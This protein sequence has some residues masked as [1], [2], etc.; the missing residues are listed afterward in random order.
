MN[1]IKKAFGA[2]LLATLIQ[3][4]EVGLVPIVEQEHTRTLVRDAFVDI[5]A[6][7][8]VKNMDISEIKSLS[9]TSP[10]SHGTA[11]YNPDNYTIRYQA[12][13]SY[14]GK[15][16]ISFTVTTKENLSADG[17]IGIT[18][19]VPSSELDASSENVYKPTMAVSQLG[20]LADAT[21]KIYELN[22][23]AVWGDGSEVLK[24]TEV[25]SPEAPSL[26]DIGVFDAH[27]AHLDSSKYYVYESIKGMDWDRDD[28]G[29]KDASATPNL[30][31]FHLIIKGNW[32]SQG[33]DVKLFITPS[34][35]LQIRKMLGKPITEDN[36]HETAAEVGAKD[37][38][39]D[40]EIDGKD[41]SLQD[42]VANKANEYGDASVDGEAMEALIDEI[43][44][45]D[46][47]T[48]E[49]GITDSNEAKLG[50]NTTKKDTD[51]DGI[52][53]GDEL[54]ID[55]DGDGKFN[56]NDNDDDGDT[57]LTKDELSEGDTDGDGKE[58]YLDNDDD[59]DG[60]LTGS[61]G[62]PVGLDRDHDGLPD[63]LE[64]LSLENKFQLIS[65]DF[66]FTDPANGVHDIWVAPRFGLGR[67]IYGMIKIPD[68]TEPEDAVEFNSKEYKVVK[69]GDEAVT[70]AIV[71]ENGDNNPADLVQ[72]GVASSVAKKGDTVFVTSYR[73]IHAYDVADPLAISFVGETNV[74]NDLRELIAKEKAD[75]IYNTT[76]Y[77]LGAFGA[78]FRVFHV[79]YDEVMDKLFV[80]TSRGVLQYTTDLALEK[81]FGQR[82]PF[83]SSA[84]AYKDKTSLNPNALYGLNRNGWLVKLNMR[85][86]EERWR[87]KNI[88][89]LPHYRFGGWGFDVEI[90]AN[91]ENAIIANYRYLTKIDLTIPATSSKMRENPRQYK[92]SVSEIDGCNRIVGVT[93]D[94]EDPDGSVY[95]S[96]GNGAI[97]HTAIPAEPVNEAG[98]HINR[99]RAM[100]LIVNDDQTKAYVVTGR[101]GSY[102]SRLRGY[103]IDIDGEFYM[104]GGY[105]EL[106]PGAFVAD[107]WFKD[108]NKNYQSRR[109]DLISNQ[110]EPPSRERLIRPGSIVFDPANQAIAYATSYRNIYEINLETGV[111]VKI[112][113]DG[114]EDRAI[115]D[116]VTGL[117]RGPLNKNT[118]KMAIASQATD[119]GNLIFGR[120][121]YSLGT[122]IAKGAPIYSTKVQDW[123]AE[124]GNRYIYH[125]LVRRNTY[126]WGMDWFDDNVF[127]ALG[128]KGV[129]KAVNADVTQDDHALVDAKTP[130]EM[131]SRGRF[132]SDIQIDPDDAP[133]TLTSNGFVESGLFLITKSRRIEQCSGSQGM[134]IVPAAGDGLAKTH[135][136]CGNKIVTVDHA[137]RDG[138]EIFPNLWY[139]A[140]YTYAKE[141]LLDYIDQPYR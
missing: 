29:V 137:I 112:A 54:Q 79:E 10:T 138:R 32:C 127:I 16:T 49:D 104:D 1:R 31:T 44:N 77:R 128:Y 136:A 109:G 55:T 30:G 93:I 46:A 27:C 89:T 123:E 18:V 37:Q 70:H 21:V 130:R 17:I 98:Q 11:Y 102:R 26:A 124:L 38:N 80:S 139:P 13:K 56:C 53:D 12:D 23:G 85:R 69:D 19:A 125:T 135:V 50:C 134:Y 105:D 84:R 81:I 65:R 3:A 68:S 36:L 83:I 64:I 101:E 110:P 33:Q 35:E 42:P 132:I 114:D 40:G 141:L 28:D 119:G 72:G 96:C 34:S 86:D 122:S 113:E 129:A 48:D 100:D 25:T 133:K 15:D 140:G 108:K 5:N 20:R 4:G 24:W 88:W 22:E 95:V 107:G 6:T 120:R 60:D 131:G 78:N 8:L 76:G 41:M 126:A 66:V 52:E 118:I 59:N 94:P 45:G 75:G 62:D 117:E 71:D 87:E 43:H 67:L 115:L 92:K 39:G 7:M 91:G 121:V 9:V 103:D 61:A 82:I 51:G 74:L 97:R 99:I 106:V 63:Y 47:D 2:M 57:V 111:A 116:S 58:N 73:G 90:T 14:I